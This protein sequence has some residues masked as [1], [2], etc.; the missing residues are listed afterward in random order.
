MSQFCRDRTNKHA[1]ENPMP[2]SQDQ[3]S[4]EHAR[5]I[6]PPRT[7]G[8]LGLNDAADPNVRAFQ[9]DTPGP[10][11]LNDHGSPQKST[12]VKAVN[13]V[14]NQADVEVLE[15]LELVESY[16]K[17][18]EAV[19][20]TYA[21]QM[22][23]YWRDG[24]DDR[25]G[26]A[27][28]DATWT[29]ILG[30]KHSGLLLPSDI[31]WPKHKK[32][33]VQALLDSH[34]ATFTA[35]AKRRL[36]DGSLGPR[37]RWQVSM[38]FQN[39]IGASSWGFSDLLFAM[40]SC[41][42]N[43]QVDVQV[44]QVKRGGASVEFNKG[45]FQLVKGDEVELHFSKWSVALSDVYIWEHGTSGM[46]GSMALMNLHY[47]VTHGKWKNPQEILH[48]LEIPYGLGD[49]DVRLYARPYDNQTEWVPLRDD[50]SGL[51]TPPL[52]GVDAKFSTQAAANFV[53]VY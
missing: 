47:F 44:A 40:G 32:A 5:D 26:A 19:G 18:A 15:A 30:K 22:M 3:H 4:H 8:P 51:V 14:H 9:G 28:K 46:P 45:A 36:A 41:T 48:L 25:R 42:L 53:V 34:R 1:G 50:I 52:D 10:V 38:V 29:D 7:P 37:Q 20:F 43:S 33:I 11:G 2:S 35:G 24:G 27:R 17:N 21:A 13:N 49:P 6:M 12:A 31:F 16:I 39:T 23:R